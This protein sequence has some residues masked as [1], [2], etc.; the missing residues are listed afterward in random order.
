MTGTRTNILGNLFPTNITV[1]S[2]E[3]LYNNG[4]DLYEWLSFE[5]LDGSSTGW[6]LNSIIFTGINPGSNP[7]FSAELNYSTTAT[8]ST[9][10]TGFS[11]T[12]PTGSPTV[13]AIDMNP[14]GGQH[15]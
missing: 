3:T 5:I 4:A 6:S 7:G 15:S 11:T 8:V 1:A 9:P 14:S 12:F 10:P 2:L 13:Y